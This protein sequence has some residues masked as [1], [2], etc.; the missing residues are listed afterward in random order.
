MA[1]FQ[2]QISD[3]SAKV[4]LGS[5][6]PMLVASS[7]VTQVTMVRPEATMPMASSMVTQVTMVRPEARLV[8]SSVEAMASMVRHQPTGAKSDG[9]VAPVMEYLLLSGPDYDVPV[10]CSRLPGCLWALQLTVST[11]LRMTLIVLTQT[12]LGSMPHHLE[13]SRAVQRRHCLFPP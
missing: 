3:L 1:A 5:S 8:P 4:N 11:Q 12:S 9:K 2:A 6:F 13:P 10:M 7:A